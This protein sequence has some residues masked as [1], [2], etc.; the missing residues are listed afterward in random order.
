[1][2]G[3]G[4]P[5]MEFAAQLRQARAAAGDPTFHKMA[6]A[7]GNYTKPSLA[8]AAR[9][10]KMPTWPVT[11]A[12][13]IACGIEDADSLAR[14]FR[15]WKTAREN[16]VRY[17]A[18]RYGKVIESAAISDAPKVPR[19]A[20]R[21]F[22]LCAVALGPEQADRYRDDWRNELHELRAEG[23]SWYGRTAYVLAVARSVP[24]LVVQWRLK[25]RRV[26]E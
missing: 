17:I 5:A 10:E 19:A 24:A 1:M 2:T 16:Y 4:G 11:Q 22:R 3:H 18:F 25:P 21:I 13:L 12:F 23:M 15:R 20:D 8:K 7:C 14:W 26:A 9:G 6:V